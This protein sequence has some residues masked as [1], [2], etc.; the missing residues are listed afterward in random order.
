MGIGLLIMIMMSISTYKQFDRGLT[1]E[2][3]LLCFILG[4]LVSIANY[5]WKLRKELRG[6]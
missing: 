3:F 4:V 6:Y 2:E 5:I 1:V